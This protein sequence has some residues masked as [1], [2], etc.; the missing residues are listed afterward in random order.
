MSVVDIQRKRH[1][2]VDGLPVWAHGCK[3]SC[4]AYARTRSMRS[5]ASIPPPR[6]QSQAFSSLVDN[7]SNVH[8]S[9]GCQGVKRELVI[10]RLSW[11]V[12]HCVRSWN[13]GSLSPGKVCSI[14]VPTEKGKMTAKCGSHVHDKPLV[15]QC[16][17]LFLFRRSSQTTRD[18]GR[19]DSWLSR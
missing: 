12:R 8:P 10:R 3:A 15:V 7:L 17:I 11:T 6:H 18:G 9:V 14:Q 5:D 1:R 2:L 13:V 19:F 4:N 16:L